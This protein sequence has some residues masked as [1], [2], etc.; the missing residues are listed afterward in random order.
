MCPTNNGVGILLLLVIIKDKK[1]SS[2]F[3]LGIYFQI[4]KR[5]IVW[6]VQIALHVYIDLFQFMKWISMMQK[7]DESNISG[8]FEFYQD[9]ILPYL[10][11]YL[12]FKFKL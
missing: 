8:Q 6:R 3:S 7:K 9:N 2:I 10:L 12:H 4:G 11:L 5:T 1:S